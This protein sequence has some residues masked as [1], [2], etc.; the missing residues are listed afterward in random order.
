MQIV[1]RGDSELDELPKRE[2]MNSAQM[3]VRYLN[4][5]PTSGPVAEPAAAR[6][7]TGINSGISNTYSTLNR[8]H[9]AVHSNED[10]DDG[11]KT[12]V[13]ELPRAV[14]IQRL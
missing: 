8:D 14:S 10:T 12:L 1:G 11:Y 5:K 7:A 13:S 6:L 3:T 2:G 9:A 4:S